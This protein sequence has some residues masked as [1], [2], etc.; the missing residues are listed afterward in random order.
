[1]SAITSELKQWNTLLPHWTRSEAVFMICILGIV[2]G[3]TLY[4]NSRDLTGLVCAVTGI[5][6]TLLAGKGNVSCYL[7]GIVNTCLYGWI[8]CENKVYG[9]ML[10]N[11]LYYLP[12]QFFGIFF[13]LKNLDKSSGEV[14]K[15]RLTLPYL[16]LAVVLTLSGWCLF[17]LILRFFGGTAPWLD[18]ATTVISITAMV[19]GVLRCF[20]QWI[21]WTLVNG[22]S[23]W[24]WWR[25]WQD[26]GNSFAAL[27]M[28]CAFLVCGLVFAVQWL[29]A[30][31]KAEACH[32]S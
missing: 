11:W 9:D 23:I 14:R 26:S 28:W 25:V 18:S 7:F 3:A 17:A 4:Q 5:C 24:L 29:N 6:Y 31:K 8:A 19:L 30:A 32:V 1:M 13:W 21:A 15:R 22:I 2:A 20:E 27:L 12:M 16:I 10:L